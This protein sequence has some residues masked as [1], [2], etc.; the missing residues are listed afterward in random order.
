MGKE[1]NRDSAVRGRKIGSAVDGWDLRRQPE[2]DRQ[3]TQS[4]RELVASGQTT[5]P[6]PPPAS[7]TRASAHAFF[8]CSF[9][10]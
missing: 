5:P 4:M 9:S 10:F 6:V 1:M 8:S 2:S 7:D 3:T